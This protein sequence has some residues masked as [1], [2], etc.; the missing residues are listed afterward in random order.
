[1][2]LRSLLSACVFDR[3]VDPGSVPDGCRA[4]NERESIKVVKP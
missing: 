1:L 2:L 3:T 4:M